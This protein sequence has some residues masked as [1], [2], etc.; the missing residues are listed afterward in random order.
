MRSFVRKVIH[1]ERMDIVKRKKL[2]SYLKSVKE[3]HEEEQMK[4]V[5]KIE[6]NRLDAAKT[7]VK[8]SLKGLSPEE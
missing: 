5:G 3:H 6:R 1:N 2:N 7:L 4:I 8:D